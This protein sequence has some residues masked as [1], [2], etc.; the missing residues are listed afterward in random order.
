MVTLT[1]GDEGPVGAFELAQYPVTNAQYRL[2]LDA[3]DGYTSAAWWDYS[4]RATRWHERHLPAELTSTGDSLPR[5]SVS[6]YEALAFCRW[7]SAETGESI[8]LPTEHE[9]QRAAQNDDDRLFPWGN[10]TDISRCN[11]SESGIKRLTPVDKFPSGAS[12][13]G[14][15][16]MSGNAAEWCLNAYNVPEDVDI[17]TFMGGE[18][19]AMRGGSYGLS[20]HNAQVAF[21]SFNHPADRFDFLGFRLV[22]HHLSA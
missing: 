14:A 1:G 22:R 7:L 9:W 2:F 20:L 18:A 12:A 17:A 5:V 6:W 21:R 10:D 13:F 19:R 3:A 4:A 11:A 16:D 15:L 8:T